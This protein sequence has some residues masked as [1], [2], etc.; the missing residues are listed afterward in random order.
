MVR[1][2]KILCLFLIVGNASAFD[3]PLLKGHVNDYAKLFSL[4]TV[5]QL[6]DKL[7]NYEKDNTRQ[8]V[9][10]TTQSLDG[11][12]IESASIKVANQ[13]KLGMAKANNG[14]L[15]F[16]SVKDRKIRIEVGSGIEDI[17][18]DIFTGRII[19]SIITPNFKEQKFDK[20]IVDAVDVLMLGTIAVKSVSNLHDIGGVVIFIVLLILL[21]IIIAKIISDSDGSGGSFISG[22]GSIFG[23]SSS[24]GYGSGGGRSSGGGSSGGW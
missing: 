18:T 14:L 5:N 1:I 13:W 23:S 4:E 2:L 6:E 11:E 19:D 21:M 8:F 15:L 16:V 20:G 10:L 3:V 12:S 17:Y 9:I 7:T 22:S 24:G